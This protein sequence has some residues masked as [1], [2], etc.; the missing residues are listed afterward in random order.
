MLSLWLAAVLA[1]GNLVPNGSFETAAP[2]GLPDAWSTSAPRDATQPN[3]LR[4]AHGGVDGN[5]AAVTIGTGAL[6]CGAWQTAAPVESEQWYRVGLSFRTDLLEHPLEHLRVVLLWLDPDGAAQRLDYLYRT[7]DITHGWTR[8]EQVLQAPAKATILSLALSLRWTSGMVWW[9][10]VTVSSA[11]PPAP[12]RV[13]LASVCFLPTGSTP[14][15]N[16]E[17]WAQQAAAAGEQ[18]ADLVCLGEGI[19]VVGTRSSYL[20]AAEP[21]PGPTTKVLGEVAKKYGMYLVAG[22]YE[23][24]G[25]AVYN[26]AVLLDRTGAVAGRYRKTHLP[27]SEIEAGLTPGD[28]YPVFYTDF[29]VLGIQIC[30]DN[31]FPEVARA[32]AL[33]G[34]EVICTPIWGDGRFGGTAW[35]VLPRARAIDNGVWYLGS[36]YSQQRSLV[37][38]PW[39]EVLA[40]TAGQ[41]GL[42]LAEV[43][44]NER[45]IQPWLSLKPGG[46]WRDLYPAERRPGTYGV[47]TR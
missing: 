33:N 22:L 44:L 38:S 16:R 28:D 42:A 36:N 30:Y 19:T 5:A 39:G 15:Q 13:K 10:D 41:T 4:D 24:D 7:A 34:A 40:D 26:T 14:E 12:R 29:G 31:D 8:L 2:N 43:D 45:R 32:L 20:E 35:D 47:L 46:D 3:W 23:Q 9:D 18:G 25:D 11:D 1:G 6:T 37:V 17:L 21:V 27:E